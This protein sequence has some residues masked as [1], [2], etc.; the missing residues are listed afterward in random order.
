MKSLNIRS[1]AILFSS[2]IILS[3]CASGYQANKFSGSETAARNTVEMVRLAYPVLAE[4]TG[5][6]VISKAT[7]NGINRFLSDSNVRYGDRLLIDRGAKVSDKRVQTLY[8]Y[9]RSLGLETGEEIGIFGAEPA[10][11]NMTI[12]LER[13]TVQTPECTGL[14][15][16]STPNHQNAPMPNFGCSNAT[17]LGLMVADP[18]DL[19]AG[20]SDTSGDT[21]KATAAVKANRKS[22]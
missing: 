9:F 18:R 14:N 8:K 12:Y 7:L 5:Q 17:V 6:D 22:K 11:G 4:N 3:G 21:E 16:P 20:K 13:H 15:T 2:C 10:A 19:V 1:K